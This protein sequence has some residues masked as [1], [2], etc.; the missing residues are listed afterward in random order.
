MKYLKDIRKKY[1]YERE[2]C[3]IEKTNADHN[4]NNNNNS[5]DS[6]LSAQRFFKK[7]FKIVGDI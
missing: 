6:K 7:F 4:N 5:L 1:R 3:A 2:Q